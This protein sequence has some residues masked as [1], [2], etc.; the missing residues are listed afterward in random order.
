MLD[1]DA[2]MRA[3]G[4]VR[5]SEEKA[6]VQDILRKSRSAALAAQCSSAGV[7][8]AAGDAPQGSKRAHD[9]TNQA[10]VNAPSTES[11]EDTSVQLPKRPRRTRRVPRRFEVV[12]PGANRGRRR[13]GRRTRDLPPPQPVTARA[14]THRTLRPVAMHAVVQRQTVFHAQVESRCKSFVVHISGVGFDGL[15]RCLAWAANSTALGACTATDKEDLECRLK[16]QVQHATAAYAMFGSIRRGADMDATSGQGHAGDLLHLA[17]S[18]MVRRAPQAGVPM[19]SLACTLQRQITVYTPRA[20]V[21]GGQG[22]QVREK[23]T[24]KPWN[25]DARVTVRILEYHVRVLC[26]Y[27]AAEGSPNTAGQ[28]HAELWP[29]HSSGG[30]G[31]GRPGG[32]TVKGS[33]LHC[34]RGVLKARL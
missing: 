4:L 2:N 18:I 26:P 20:R 16:R 25:C 17:G 13:Q 8:G 24:Q 6:F 11:E 28:R 1:A 15:L 22:V 10:G 19:T 33:V 7:D 31:H 27:R 34:C 32:V 5:N 12:P 9:T 29:P 30:R 21:A 23:A 14:G 3:H